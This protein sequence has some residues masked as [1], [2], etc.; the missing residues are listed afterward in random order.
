VFENTHRQIHAIA[1]RKIQRFQSL[2]LLLGGE[3]VPIIGQDEGG[4]QSFNQL[5]P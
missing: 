1:T 5:N 3:A 2:F 4:P